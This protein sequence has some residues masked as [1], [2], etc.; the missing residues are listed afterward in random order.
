MN[1]V[2]AWHCHA[3]TTEG[4]ENRESYPYSATP[5]TDIPAR[6]FQ[7]NYPDKADFESVETKF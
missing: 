7:L 2:G 5:P 4:I 6:M 1:F 3:P